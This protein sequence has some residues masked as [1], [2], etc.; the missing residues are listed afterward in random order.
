M[1]R[2]SPADLL[3]AVTELTALHAPAGRED[4]VIRHLHR[5]LAPLSDRLELDPFGNLYAFRHGPEG[6]RRLVIT[7]HAD[8][9][10][11]IVRSIDERGFVRFA[12]VGSPHSQLLPGRRVRVGDH[13]GVIGIKSDHRLT[14]KEREERS[15]PHFSELY[16]DLGVDGPEQVAELGIHPG[17]QITFVSELL[18]LGGGNRYA[19]KSVDNR[20]SCAL[21]LQ[22]FR[23]LEG[24]E[25]P[26]TVVGMVTVQEEVG[27]RGA[28]VAT[29]RLEP[30]LVLALDVTVCDDT[31]EYDNPGVGH[32]RLGRGPVLHWMEQA[33]GSHRGMLAHPWVL[34][35]LIR[36]AEREEVP[37]QRGLL[38]G[39]LTDASKIHSTGRGAAACYVGLP[40]RYVHSPVEV[41]DLDDAVHASR[42]VEGF[43]F[44]EAADV[45][46]HRIRV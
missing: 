1:S 39:G 17:T 41:F 7:A 31:P 9:I 26:V 14:R 22:L 23:A 2:T 15:V 46:L 35:A 6:G 18:R 32:L 12:P 40:C 38:V 25:L 42:L 36:V 20:L 19:G 13:E 44:H 4:A 28:G 8:E 16:I 37:Y 10:G 45:D 27:M 5:R 29:H 34:E 24:R 11:L 3:D 33:G 30:E 43:V 21:L